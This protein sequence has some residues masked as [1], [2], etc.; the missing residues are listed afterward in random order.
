MVAFMA[1]P[2]DIQRLIG[3]LAREGVVESVDLAAGTA[4]VQFADELTTGDIPWLSSRAGDTR[5]WSPPS[6]GEQVLVI[7]PEADA[8]RGIIIGSLSSDARPHPASDTKTL[9]DFVDGALIGYDPVTHALTAYLPAGATVNI[10]AP[11]GLQFEGDLTV[12]GNIRSTGKVAADD[13]V[14]AGGKSL[15][16]HV[17]KG[18][19]AGAAMSGPPA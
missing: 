13:D 14:L 1:D 9:A 11:G 19:Q 16:T 5:I 6:I 3:D 17:H 15:K 2:T 8:A 12:D 10:V 4:R 18:V 7:A